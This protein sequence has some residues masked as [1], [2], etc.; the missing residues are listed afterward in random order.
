MQTTIY[1]DY[2]LRDLMND[3]FKTGEVSVII[4]KQ[5]SSMTCYS[6][7]TAMTFRMVSWVII[8][9]QML[10]NNGGFFK[11]KIF[12]IPISSIF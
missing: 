2:E 6:Y 4:Q 3:V 1:K 11:Q 7:V 8:L 9:Y 10:R 12:V 5:N